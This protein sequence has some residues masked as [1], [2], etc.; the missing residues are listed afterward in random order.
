MTEPPA[1][2]PPDPTADPP[3]F[4]TPQSPPYPSDGGGYPTYQSGSAR[5]EPPTAGLPPSYPPVTAPPAYGQGPTGGSR[6]LVLGVA[7]ALVFAIA[8]CGVIGVAG[9]LVLGNDKSGTASEPVAVTPSQAPTEAPGQV[10]PT[11]FPT[12]FP[13]RSLFPVPGMPDDKPHDIVYEV[14]GAADTATVVYLGADDV[15]V[16]TQQ[17]NLPWRKE[18]TPGTGIVATTVTAFSPLGKTISCRITVDGQQV[19][20]DTDNAMVVCIGMVR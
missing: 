20:A 7:V 8:L 6:R 16:E 11:D 17:V 3:P 9:L 1:S 4:S 14:T 18:I 10:L 15:S 12:V 19:A 13:L 2:P 5:V